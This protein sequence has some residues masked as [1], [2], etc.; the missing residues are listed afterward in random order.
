M[1]PDNAVL[2]NRNFT[3]L[4]LGGTISDPFIPNQTSGKPS[5]IN[6]IHILW[7]TQ[8]GTILNKF[9]F[10]WFRKCWILKHDWIFRKHDD[11]FPSKLIC[12]SYSFPLLEAY[13][14]CTSLLVIKRHIP[15]SRGD[16]TTMNNPKMLQLLLFFNIFPENG[17]TVRWWTPCPWNDRGRWSGWHSVL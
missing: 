17:P 12:S 11:K 16:N 13:R 14:L 2:Y 6:Q 15:D 8:T 7:L 5:L 10:L 9:Y 3:F 1:K 4:P